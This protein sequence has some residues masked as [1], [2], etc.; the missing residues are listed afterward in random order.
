MHFSGFHDPK[1]MNNG[2]VTS[3]EGSEVDIQT[4]KVHHTWHRRTQGRRHI[5]SQGSICCL[6]SWSSAHNSPPTVQKCSKK[7]WDFHGE[8]LIVI[9]CRASNHKDLKGSYLLFKKIKM[10]LYSIL[11]KRSFHTCLHLNLLTDIWIST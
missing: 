2:D 10:Y 8:V 1:K 4:H 6:F 5:Q 11:I 3:L 7:K 9:V